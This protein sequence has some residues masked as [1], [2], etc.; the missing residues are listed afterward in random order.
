ME[1]TLVT[2]ATT[3]PARFD[4]KRTLRVSRESKRSLECMKRLVAMNV[5]KNLMLK[6]QKNDAM[7]VGFE[8]NLPETCSLTYGAAALK[9]DD[10]LINCV[11][12]T[13]V[14]FNKFEKFVKQQ[15]IWPLQSSVHLNWN[16]EKLFVVVVKTSSSVYSIIDDVLFNHAFLV[17]YAGII[18]PYFVES[19]RLSVIF[20]ESCNVIARHLKTSFDRSILNS[21][22]ILD[23][24][25]PEL[26]AYRVIYSTNQANALSVAK[27]NISV[28]NNK[29][30]FSRFAAVLLEH[31]IKS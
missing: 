19:D 10:K 22:L 7:I 13:K 3:D 17:D 1:S 9:L 28:K 14:H 15:I 8:G 6:N 2:D 21:G 5:G 18:V 4:I 24:F 26:N 16:N 23:P 30:E 27:L 25:H 20:E 12:G 29:D 31:N 11:T